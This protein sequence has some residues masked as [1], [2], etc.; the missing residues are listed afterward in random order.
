MATKKNQEIKALS[1]EELQQE[2]SANET[3]LN[4]MKFDNAVTGLD[5]PLQIRETRRDVARIKTELRSREMSEMTESQIAK[6]SKIRARRA[7][8]R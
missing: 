4:K 3:Q 7:K 8:K 5:N 1:T 2:L 6:R